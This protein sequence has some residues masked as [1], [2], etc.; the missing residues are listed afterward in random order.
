[1]SRSAFI[2]CSRALV[3]ALFLGVSSQGRAVIGAFRF[4]PIHRACNRTPRTIFISSVRGPSPLATDRNHLAKTH[5]RRWLLQ[6]PSP[7]TEL[8]NLAPAARDEATKA[9]KS[10]RPGGR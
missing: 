1:V 7:V 8:S 3:G 4:E 6:E 10:G 2:A 9:L 5:P